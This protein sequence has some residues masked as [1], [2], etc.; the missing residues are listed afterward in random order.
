M[1]KRI[2]AAAVAALTVLVGIGAAPAHADDESPT[3]PL[4][5]SRVLCVHPTFTVTGSG[6]KIQKAVELW[7]QAQG[8]VRLTTVDEPGCDV[9]YVHRYSADDGWCGYTAWDRTWGQ[10]HFDD[11]GSWVVS[12]GDIYLNDLCVLALPRYATRRIVAHELGHAMGLPHSGDPSSV[13]D[14]T[15]VHDRSQPLVAA[16][17]VKDLAALYAV[18]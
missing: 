18:A 12:G 17:D 10:G 9:Y 16:V 13:M 5:P 6:W 2:A 8:T 11:A 14:V 4:L 15:A 1:W 7:N 3:P